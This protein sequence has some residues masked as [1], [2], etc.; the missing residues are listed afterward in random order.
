MQIAILDCYTDEPAGLGVP[1]YLGTYPRYMY[2][3]LR[4]QHKEVYYFTIDDLRLWKKYNE[5]DPNKDLKKSQTTNNRVYNLTKYHQQIAEILAHAEELII[6][7]G[8]HVPGKYLSAMPGTIHEV[9]ELLKDVK[10]KKILTGPAIFGTQLFGG[11]KSES[12][13]GFE[14]KDYCFSFDEIKEYAVAGAEIA[15]QIPW[16]KIIEIETGRGCKGKCSFCIEPLKSTVMFRDNKDIL[17][18]IK[19]YYDS[20]ERYFRLG[21]QTCFYSIPEPI[22][23]LKSIRESCPGIRVLHIDNVNPVQVI[24]KRGED[25]TQAIVKYCT[26]GNIAAFGIESFDEDVVKANT[27]NCTPTV[28]MRA[29]EII[30]KYGKEYGDNGMPKFLPGINLIFGLAEE[31]KKTQGENMRYLK[32][33]LDKDLWLRRI[34]IRQVA[35]FEATKMHEIG[36]KYLKKNKKYYWKWRNQIRQEIDLP[37]LK[38]V[39]PKGTIL[40]EMYAEIYDG[41]TTFMRQFGTYPLIAGV[42]GRYPLKQFYTVKI[43]DYMIR[44]LVGEVV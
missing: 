24:T 17:A 18:E 44:S 9:T 7:L 39:M 23:L 13:Q 29:I 1:P 41:N 12:I 15:E 19:A 16:L 4:Q 22:E 28:A 3:Y 34:N 8:V 14:T 26:A 25:I 11:R 33:C 10:C 43:I 20:G 40:K 36:E 37:M 6:I 30:N 21:K 42:K 2:G 27:L 32:Q 38:K 35:L 31:S 5:R